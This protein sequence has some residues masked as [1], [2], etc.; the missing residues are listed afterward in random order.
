MS[1]ETRLK[2]LLRP[3][4]TNRAWPD[5]RP[6]ASVKTTPFITW[7]QIGGETISFL[8]GGHPGKRNARV[9]INVWASDRETANTLMRTVEVALLNEARSTSALGALTALYEQDMALYGARQDYSL[10]QAD[11]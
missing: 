5:F 1:L 11:D 9:Q 6:S 2:T 4:V 3:L 7:Q 10:W 8:E